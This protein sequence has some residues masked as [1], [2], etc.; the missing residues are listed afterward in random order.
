MLLV[1]HSACYCSVCKDSHL[2]HAHVANT[3]TVRFWW[4]VVQLLTL[5]HAGASY[6]GGGGNGGGSFAGGFA[7]G[8]NFER[9]G[10]GAP[11]RSGKMRP[12]DELPDDCKL[13]VGNLSPNITDDTL[14]AMMAPFGNVL[15]AVVLL[16][17]VTQQ[18]RGYGFVHMDNASSAGSAAQAL[19]G[20]PVD[21]KPLVVRQRSEPPGGRPMGGLDTSR[22]FGVGN[23]DDSK[24]FVGG[25]SQN[26]TDDML[27]QIFGT[28]G[29][30]LDVRL[31]TDRDTNL[32]K[33][34]GFVTMDSPGA[35]HSAITGLSGYKLG[36]KTI[37]VR[38][39]GANKGAP[40]MGFTPA[41]ATGF[42]GGPGAQRPYGGPQGL[43][44]AGPG[45][46]PYGPGGPAAGP[47]AGQY[48]RPG[49]SPAGYGPPAA[50]Y[51]TPP[52]GYGP[53]QTSAPAGYGPPAGYG[54]PAGFSQPPAGYGPPAGYSQYPPAG[55]SMP[56]PGYGPPAGYGQ[57]P[58]AS[59]QAVPAA[60]QTAAYALPQAQQPPAAYAQP[61]QPPLPQDTS[62]PP[63]PKDEKV[64][65]EYE[66]FMSEIG[67]P[68]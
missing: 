19:S 67:L 45:A 36:D 66:R 42:P 59:Q 11:A 29:V 40:G 54:Q 25:I 56:P 38:M 52:A 31:I 15:H 3:V 33:G 48:P 13:Y 8:N 10:L 20:K 35:A 58:V 26:I 23:R 14:K 65:S 41:P 55:Y 64:Q 44:P 28:Y 57:I 5:T 12:G 24:L 6:G 16:D 9:P 60:P 17:M 63:L 61:E 46:S 27:R 50:T 2:T 51:G 62:A 1:C 37:S 53:P 43:S 21:G 34:Y 32:P 4:Y 7:G 47:G 30:V 22:P 49:Q 39:A 18:S 68:R